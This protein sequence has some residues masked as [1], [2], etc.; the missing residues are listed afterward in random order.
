[1]ELAMLNSSNLASSK[2]NAQS[3]RNNYDGALIDLQYKLIK[4]FTDFYTIIKENPSLAQKFIFLNCVFNIALREGSRFQHKE[5]LYNLVQEFAVECAHYNTQALGIIDNDLWNHI[6]CIN[7]H[8][9][10]NQH[11]KATIRFFKIIPLLPLLPFIPSAREEIS[12]S[13]YIS[14][15]DPILSFTKPFEQFLEETGLD[16]PKIMD[17]LKEIKGLLFSSLPTEHIY[18]ILKFH[19]EV[20]L[21]PTIKIYNAPVSFYVNSCRRL[22]DSFGKVDNPLGTEERHL[23]PILE[24]CKSYRGLSKKEFS[25]VVGLPNQGQF[26]IFGKGQ[27]IYAII[28]Y[29]KGG[30]V[31]QLKNE[32]FELLIDTCIK[33]NDEAF[34]ITHCIGDLITSG[35]ILNPKMQI[36][37]LSVLIINYNVYYSLIGPL[38]GYGSPRQLFE[39]LIASIGAQITEEEVISTLYRLLKK[40]GDDD[41][42]ASFRKIITPLLDD[43]ILNGKHSLINQ[44]TIKSIFAESGREIWRL[45]NF[46]FLSSRLVKE[47]LSIEGL[48][49]ILHGVHISTDP[50][51]IKKVIKQL[52]TFNPPGSETHLPEEN[53]LLWSVLSSHSFYFVKF[54]Y[55]MADLY[56]KKIAEKLPLITEA[57]EHYIHDGQNKF[58]I[59]CN[60]KLFKSLDLL[61]PDNVSFDF[62]GLSML[63]LDGSAYKLLPIDSR[64]L[65]TFPAWIRNLYGV[66]QLPNKE[67]LPNWFFQD[68]LPFLLTKYRDALAEIQQLSKPEELLNA[69]DSYVELLLANS[70]LLDGFSTIVQDGTPRFSSSLRNLVKSLDDMIEGFNYT[71]KSNIHQLAYNKFVNQYFVDEYFRADNENAERN[72]GI[73]EDK[74]KQLYLIGIIAGMIAGVNGLGEERNSINFFR[75]LAGHIMQDLEAFLDNI[76]GESNRQN[77]ANELLRTNKCSNSIISPLLSHPYTKKVINEYADESFITNQ[78][79][80]I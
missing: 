3:V 56:R 52:M 48:A 7:T 26:T 74:I 61:R 62:S 70:E 72:C 18:S 34:S 77:F 49:K 75:F 22:T 23:I 6:L 59:I 8:T 66:S 24:V 64:S 17:D 25:Y 10:D 13:Q 40:A 41:L 32:L 63:Q 5:S 38:M 58:I 45:I 42:L 60:D 43:Y 11:L 73:E 53:K 65:R 54:R 29:I 12:S 33:Y 47:N 4:Q 2:I 51:I 57:G 35:C 31:T 69:F 20:I 46:E 15:A 9:H 50:K 21:D 27:I 14:G 78:T 80:T 19:L 79:D 76:V 67:V 30:Q 68:G 71:Y 16:K 44:L 39:E 55:Y 28:E 1:M 37:F 36:N